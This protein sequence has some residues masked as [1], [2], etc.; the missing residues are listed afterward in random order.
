[1]RVRVVCPI[2]S[3]PLER[4]HKA[5]SKRVRSSKGKCLAYTL[6]ELVR[7][8]KAFASQSYYAKVRVKR[9]QP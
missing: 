7:L 5:P 9:A 3:P 2:V 4:V 8:S 6:A 1:M